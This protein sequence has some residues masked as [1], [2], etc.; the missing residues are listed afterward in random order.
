[1]IP[2]IC[3]GLPAEQQ[4]ALHYLVKVPLVYTSVALRNWSAF[5]KLGI[6]NVSS[7]GMWHPSV[8][9]STGGPAIGDYKARIR[10]AR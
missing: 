10:V 9:L 3:P 6:S 8:G 5:E 4:E 1:M 2:D 7:P